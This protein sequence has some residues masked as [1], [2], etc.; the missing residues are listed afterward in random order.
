M[1]GGLRSLSELRAELDSVESDISSK[2][3]ASDV[4]NRQHERYGRDIDRVRGEIQVERDRTG[5]DERRG[6]HLRKS[7]SDDD[8]DDNPADSDASDMPE[9]LDYVRQ[10]E[11]YY[12]LRDAI[13]TW[14]RR[15]EIARTKAGMM[16]SVRE[17]AATGKGGNGNGSRVVRNE[18]DVGRG[19]G[20]G[21][22]RKRSSNRCRL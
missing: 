17:N 21:G 15:L 18:A 14:E 8:D 22:G 1:R 4:R 19:G 9:I 7:A 13:K 20:R 16:S 10:K 3:K 11:K 12:S 2:R 5:N 6:G